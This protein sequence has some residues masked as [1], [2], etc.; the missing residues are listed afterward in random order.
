MT[1]AGEIVTPRAW[2]RLLVGVAAV[3]ALFQVLAERTG[4]MRGEAGLVVCAAVVA[5][6]LL[7]ERVLLQSAVAARSL[8]VPRRR[9]M[10]AAVGVSAGMLAVFP[11][12]AWLEGGEL[13]IDE[14][15]PRLLP[16]LF[17]QAGIGEEILFRALLFAQVR[18]GRSF[19]RAVVLS[20]VPFVGVHLFLFVTLPWPIALASVLLAAVISAPL[21]WLYELCGG[22]IWGP[23]L[24]HFVVQGAIKL[25]SI[26]GAPS[27]PLI[28]MAASAV[29]PFAVFGVRSAPRL[30]S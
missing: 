6:V 4:S 9:G 19:W 28:W 15:T 11:L 8:G 13:A 12:V 18:R 5:A 23:A 20:A 7:V 21:A 16:G 29:V 10:L 30:P 25:I 22:T 26:E 1:S 2:G 17:A 24:L 3:F 27:L 14:D